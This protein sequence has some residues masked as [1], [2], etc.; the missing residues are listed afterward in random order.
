MRPNQLK[1]TTMNPETR[2][3]LQVSIEDDKAEI[4]E[5]RVNDLM[6]KK[7]ELRFKFITEQSAL[8]QNDVK[9]QLDI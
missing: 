3:L 1:E 7:P 9:E 6:G 4:A 5:Q 8:M 2:I